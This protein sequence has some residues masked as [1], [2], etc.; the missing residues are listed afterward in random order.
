LSSGSNP[1]PAFAAWRLAHSLPLMHN[2]A[3]AARGA[4]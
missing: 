4:R 2:L 1:I 3:L